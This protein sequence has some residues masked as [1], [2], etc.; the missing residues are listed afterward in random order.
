MDT[1]GK[2]GQNTPPP[3]QQPC[4]M[5]P[6]GQVQQYQAPP[7]G[8]AP[9]PTYVQPAP[10]PYYAAPPPSEQ[11]VTHRR[12]EG[13]GQVALSFGGGVADFVRDKIRDNAGTAGSWDARLLIGAYSILAFEAAY[14][15][16]AQTAFDV[17]NQPTIYSSQVFGVARLNLTRR[18]FQPFLFAGGGWANLHRTQSA[19]ESPIASQTFNKNNNAAVVQMGGGFAGYL[20]RHTTIDARFGYH[21]IADKDFTNTGARPDMWVAELRAGYVF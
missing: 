2:N 4:P 20:G 16:S 15:G 17:G 12:H 10:E 1:S 9:P 11:V 3:Q 19:E 8:Y 5:P 14:L 21:L 7:P 6:Q 18:A 13:P